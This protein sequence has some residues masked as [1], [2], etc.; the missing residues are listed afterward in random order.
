MRGGGGLVEL[1]W[2]IVPQSLRGI[3]VPCLQG[4]ALTVNLTLESLSPPVVELWNYGGNYYFEFLLQT[5]GQSLSP[6][7]SP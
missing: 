7:H 4:R 3:H 2:I 6:L 5:L 1:H